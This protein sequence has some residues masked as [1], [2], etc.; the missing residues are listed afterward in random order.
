MDDIIKKIKGN[1]G[2]QSNWINVLI[3]L[4]EVQNNS[5]NKFFNGIVKQNIK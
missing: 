3:K 4:K 5:Y 2:D 1:S